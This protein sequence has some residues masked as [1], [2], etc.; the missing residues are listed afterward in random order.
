MVELWIVLAISL[1]ALGVL[2]VAIY[3]L[4]RRVK[5]LS[6]AM[7]GLQDELQP[8]LTELKRGSSEATE[9]LEKLQRRA[10]ERKAGARLGR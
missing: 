1:M 5:T 2:A 9:R 3:A 6:S 10:A 8:L 7:R 4:V